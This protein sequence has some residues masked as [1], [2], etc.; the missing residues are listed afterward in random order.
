MDR[1]DPGGPV[2]VVDPITELHE[3]VKQDNEAKGIPHGTQTIEQN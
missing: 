3:S 2:I 1:P